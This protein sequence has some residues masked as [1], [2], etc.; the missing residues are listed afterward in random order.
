VV[1][2]FMKQGIDPLR[3]EIVGFGEF[4]PRQKNATPEGRNANRR[5]AVL[6]LEEVAPGSTV[7]ARADQHTPQVA[8]PGVETADASSAENRLPGRVPPAELDKTVLV[9]NQA[10][11]AR[12][13]AQQIA[14]TELAWPGP[15]T[16]ASKAPPPEHD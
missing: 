4:H 3:L 10:K 12:S 6:V 13:R 14:P 15:E 7:T 11:P 5:V 1:H 9:Q 2:Q 8:A 16:S